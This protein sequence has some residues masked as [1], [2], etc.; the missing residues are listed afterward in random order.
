M[1]RNSLII[2][3]ALG[4]MLASQSAGA[5]D[6]CGQP[7]GGQYAEE[8]VCV[9]VLALPNGKPA[10]ATMLDSVPDTYPWLFLF[11][12]GAP[13]PRQTIKISGAAE[14]FSSLQFING[15]ANY[16][17]SGAESSQF[18]NFSRVKDILI[19]TSSGHSV[20]HTLS[21]TEEAQFV[22]LSEP[23]AKDEVSIK[24]LS[25]YHGASGVVALRWFA[26]VWEDGL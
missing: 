15:W 7:R 9:N 14:G 12:P 24:V 10:P 18:Q 1:A 22:T 6:K 8:Q 3:A 16:D 19:E 20:P 4:H 17:T 23:L 26:I 21:D 13:P 5:E 11:E 2:L 25:V